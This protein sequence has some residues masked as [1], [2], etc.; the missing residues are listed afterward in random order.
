MVAPAALWLL[1]EPTVTLDEAS[2][3]AVEALI[4]EHR[5]NGGM[6]MVATHADMAIPGAG[7]LTLGADTG[8]RP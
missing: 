1:D 2:V 6:V 3:A 7:V 5:A 4:A 8:G